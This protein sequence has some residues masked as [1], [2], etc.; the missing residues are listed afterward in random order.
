M[1]IPA[2]R[3]RS[4]LLNPRTP[5][6]PDLKSGAVVLAWLPPRGAH[7]PVGIMAFCVPARSGYAFVAA[8]DCSPEGEGRRD[9]TPGNIFPPAFVAERDA[10]S[11]HLA[12]DLAKIGRASCRERRKSSVVAVTGKEKQIR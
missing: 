12:R 6:R 10:D 11:H 5:A 2:P 3:Y 7:R 9:H 1:G 8:F 4:G